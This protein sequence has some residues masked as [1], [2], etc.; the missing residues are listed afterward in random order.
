MATVFSAPEGYD[1]PVLTGEDFRANTWE[2]K[3]DAYIARLSDRA[4]MNGTNPLIG[5][6][7]RWQRADGFAQYLVWQ[8]KPLQLIHLELGDAYSVED[9]LIRGLRLADIRAM[10][11][12]EQRIREFFARKADES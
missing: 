1:P 4:K 6:V 12:R 9:V 10:V 2:D 11:A 5:E 8:T 3:E 7:V